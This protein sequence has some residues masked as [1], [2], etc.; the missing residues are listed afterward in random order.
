MQGSHPGTV[1]GL[2]MSNLRGITRPPWFCLTLQGFF[3]FFSTRMKADY[4]C[5]V[6]CNNALCIVHS[7]A[8]AR[9]AALN[10]RF[11]TLIAWNY[12]CKFTRPA[13]TKSPGVQNFCQPAFIIKERERKKKTEWGRWQLSSKSTGRH[14]RAGVFFFFFWECFLSRPCILLYQA[15]K[16][17]KLN[18]DGGNFHQSPRV[19]I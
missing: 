3:L 10:V 15:Y 11:V 16:K 18:G 2:K 4:H 5:I 8:A 14:L 17:K 7:A 19:D 6:P 9:V 13:L 1:N 12:L